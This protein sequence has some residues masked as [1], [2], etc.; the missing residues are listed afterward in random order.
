VGN[1]VRSGNANVGRLSETLKQLND[2]DRA[3]E[4]L[5]LA[6]GE[7]TRAAEAGELV[8]PMRWAMLSDE[9]SKF[10]DLSASRG[11]VRTSL[12][13]PVRDALDREKHAALQFASSCRTLLVLGR[14]DPAAVQSAMPRFLH[15]LKRLEKAHLDG[16]DL[17]V[18]EIATTAKETASNGARNIDGVLAGGLVIVGIFSWITVWLRRRLL[19]PLASIA[20][21][22]RNF[23]SEEV[24]AAIPGFNR[25]DELGDLAR[26]LA[27]YRAAYEERRKAEHRAA[28]L[29]QHDPL[30]GI[31]NRLLF[32]SR[33]IHELD[34]AKETGNSIAVLAIDVDDFKA[35]ND[36]YGHA[37][38]DR[39]LQRTAKLLLNSV[40]KRDLVARLGGDEFAIIQVVTPQP[41]AAEAL[42]SRLFEASAA[43]ASEDIGIRMSIGV[44]VSQ[45]ETSGQDLHH[46]AD[47]ALYQAKAEGRNTARFFDE[48]LKEQEGLRLRLARDLEQARSSHARIVF[49]A[50]SISSNWTG[51]LVFC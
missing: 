35:I 31:A 48:S 39:A 43:T 16:R 34:R 30:T 23:T 9:I 20:A 27:E 33:L 4:Q 2:H 7:T 18:R 44:A 32:E 51:R 28:F 40:S 47:L 5:R 41:E 13:K 26:G 37:G 29:A 17:I 10:E 21:R 25:P 50:V 11:A 8:S 42:I 38:G 36:R 3:Q 15:M 24:D 19:T 14:T 45:P 46:L 49:R 22:L 12:P 6:I 1:S